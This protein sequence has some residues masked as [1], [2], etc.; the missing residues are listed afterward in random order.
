MLSADIGE[1][2]QKSLRQKPERRGA[3]QIAAIA[4]G[5]DAGQYDLAI[6]AVDELAGLIDDG[7]HR[8]GAGIAA[9]IGNDAES[10]AMVAA[11]LHL[12][13]RAHMAVD[14]PDHLRRRRL[15]AHDVVDPELLFSRNAEIRQ[16]AIGGAR[17]L[18]LV[19]EH[20]ID[21]RHRGEGLLF[22]LR[23]AAG[24]DDAGMRMVA[25]RPADRLAGLAHGLTGHRTG[26][27]QDG[28]VEPGLLSLRLHH[29]G[30]ICVEAAAEGND[31]DA[32]HCASASRVP[33]RDQRPVEGS[34]LPDH[35]HSAGPVMMT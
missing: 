29:F 18:L 6:T 7:S 34:T 35:S 9:A 33:S 3:R 27:D 17:Q 23:G 4:G 19:A 28:V 2:L 31:L 26:V 15:D 14:V 20:G 16:A 12:D 22:R 25:P 13:E 30:F 5:I 8:Y 10:A 24:N 11:I 21:L 32:A 1:L